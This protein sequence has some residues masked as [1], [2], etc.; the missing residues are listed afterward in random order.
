ML[1]ACTTNWVGKSPTSGHDVL[2]VLSQRSSQ[3]LFHTQDRRAEL[4]GPAHGGAAAVP[5]RDQL[6]AKRFLGRLLPLDAPGQAAR[7]RV[8]NPELVPLLLQGKRY[9]VPGAGTAQ[10]AGRRVQE[11]ARRARDAE[12]FAGS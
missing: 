6:P 9:V 1:P 10:D 5:V 7:L 11:L 8:P 4:D 2:Y 3:P 12:R